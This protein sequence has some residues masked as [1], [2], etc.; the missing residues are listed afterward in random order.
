MAYRS[1]LPVGRWRTGADS[2]RPREWIIVCRM[3]HHCRFERSIR[4][5]HEDIA[6]RIVTES[7][8]APGACPVKGWPGASR[9]DARPGVA[10]GVFRWRRIPRRSRPSIPVRSRPA[11]ALSGD[12]ARAN[13]R[14]TD[15]HRSCRLASSGASRISTCS[16]VAPGC[17]ELPAVRRPPSASETDRR[18]A[19]PNNRFRPVLISQTA[20]RDCSSRYASRSPTGTLPTHRP[21]RRRRPRP[22]GG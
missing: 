10:S 9:S 17:S 8:A 1:V 6:V 14:V 22:R 12:Q 13:A 2:W 5:S 4:V 18:A 11:R 3:L 21:N 15:H 7:F 19:C 16:P 20:R